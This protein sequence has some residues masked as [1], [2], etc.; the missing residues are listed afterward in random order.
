VSGIGRGGFRPPSRRSSLLTAPSSAVALP[1]AV[2]GVDG[3]GA[4][5][6]LIPSV[7]GSVDADGASRRD[8][9]HEERESDRRRLRLDHVGAAIQ[10]LP[11]PMRDDALPNGKRELRHPHLLCAELDRGRSDAAENAGNPLTNHTGSLPPRGA[12]WVKHNCTR[13][14][15]VRQ[16]ES[17]ESLC[18]S[19]SQVIHRAWAALSTGIRCHAQKPSQ[20]SI[21][22]EWVPM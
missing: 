18:T 11:L 1:A 5:R 16:E 8:A 15:P 10:P 19:Y 2:G 3:V 14:P 17:R 9:L 13:P 20:D 7:A 4:G 6:A 22:D 12:V 21:F